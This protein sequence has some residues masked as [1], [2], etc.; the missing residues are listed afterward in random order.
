MVAGILFATCLALAISAATAAGDF[1]EVPSNLSRY[2]P[3]DIL[4]AE[5][6]PNTPSP[7]NGTTAIRI[8]YLS[9]DGGHRPIAITGMVFAPVKGEAPHGGWP[10]ISYTHGTTGVGDACAPSKHADLYWADNAWFVGKLVRD[11]FVV[12]V[13][14]YQ[15]LGTPGLHPYL[16]LDSEARSAI[17]AVAAVRH[18]VPA[19]SSTWAVVGHSQGG[20]AALG[21]GEL[22]ADLQKRGQTFVGTVSLAPGSHLETLGPLADSPD[23]GWDLLAY[24]AASIKASNPYFDY[25][26]MLVPPLLTEMP[27]AEETCEVELF[28]YFSTTYRVGTGLNPYWLESRSV[29]SWLARN[30]PGQRRSSG[31]ILLIQGRRDAI[32]PAWITNDLFGRL[33]ANGDVVDYHLLR[34]DHDAVQFQGYTTV[35]SWLRDRFAGTPAPSSCP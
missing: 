4:K 32:I 2:R 31:P 33:C 18:V 12:A 15:G 19:A 26:E 28:E 3:G 21:T 30:E 35:L 1:Y 34:G 6:V 22:A 5:L 27:R 16:E 20:H 17:D 11:G 25:S 29:R 24:V 14:D 7:L 10:V 9:S 23:R 8:M 13:T